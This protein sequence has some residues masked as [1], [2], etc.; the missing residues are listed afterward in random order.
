VNLSMVLTWSLLSRLKPA[1]I[2][3]LI[4]SLRVMIKTVALH[5]SAEQIFNIVIQFLLF[6]VCLKG[7]IFKSIQ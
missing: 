5:L 1:I 2:G 6:Y 4:K 7:F 3:L